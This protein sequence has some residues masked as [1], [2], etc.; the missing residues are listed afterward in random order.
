MTAQ[1]D[2]AMAVLDNLLDGI[3]L[4]T[5]LFE[6]KTKEILHVKATVAAT[7]EAGEFSA[8]ISSVRPDRERDIVQPAALVN[9]MKAWGANAKLVPLAW[10]HNTDPEEIVGHVNPD[11]VKSV[12][13]E[14]HADGWID[15]DTPRGQQVWRLVKSNTLGFSYGY[16]VTDAVERD[17][18]GREIRGLDI[19]EVS[20]TAVPANA[21]T[22][23]LSWKSTDDEPDPEQMRRD[24]EAQAEELRARSREL[25]RELGLEDPDIA[26]MREMGRGWVTPYSRNGDDT[27][28]L[29]PSQQLRAKSDA[30]AK[31]HA[32]I[33]IASFEC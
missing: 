1:Y 16:L 3:N 29:T 28:T 27:K 19:F 7:T 32:A 12:D 30:R 17:G 5:P 25:E 20:A 10:Q 4:D 2:Q 15:R 9:A 11:S 26:A 33:V 23:V 6:P 14:V 18:G 24:L 21:D 8:V 31:Q 22:R 13:G